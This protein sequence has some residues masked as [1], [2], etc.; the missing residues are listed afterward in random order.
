MSKVF[1]IDVAKCS[2][3]YS[4][5]MACKDEFADNDWSPYSKPQPD[6]GQFWTK[7]KEDVQ[8]TIPKVKVS[9]TVQMCNH[10]RNPK[11]MP[12]CT[13][14]AIY[15]RED[16]FII[17]NPEKCNGCGACQNAC[18]YGAIY[19]NEK[20]GICQKCTGCAHLLDNGYKM[21][22]CVENCPTDAI[23]F[24]EEEELQE[25]ITG[26]VVLDP[27]TGCRPR[28]YYRNIPGKFIAGLVYDPEEEEVLIGA[29]CIAVTG[30]KIIETYTDDFGDF[31]FK[32]LVIGSY[33]ITIFADG[34]K[35]YHKFGIRTDTSVNLGDIPLEK[36]DKNEDRGMTLKNDI[37]I[38]S[39]SAGF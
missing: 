20:I 39:N 34:Y 9:Y 27:E 6:T 16:G 4:C 24:G 14:D 17:I 37:D 2:G 3:C 23:T 35:E 15:R 13:N 11:C 29:R 25:L 22:R 38:F 30:G 28:V 19:K 32:D 18:P 5:Q 12:A 33:D 7:L 21:P 10:C 8:G 26:A 36:A 31:W 1:V